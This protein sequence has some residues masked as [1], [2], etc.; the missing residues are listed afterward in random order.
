MISRRNIN[1]GTN[2]MANV[3]DFHNEVII[4]FI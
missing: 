2:T 4:V 3:Y 1:K